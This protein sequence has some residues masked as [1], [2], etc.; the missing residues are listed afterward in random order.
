MNVFTVA[1][2]EDL[3]VF[4]PAFAMQLARYLSG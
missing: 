4:L 2:R 3:Q 1:E